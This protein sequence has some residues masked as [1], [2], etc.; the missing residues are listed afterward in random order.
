L[1]VRGRHLYDRC[2]EQVVL[3]GVNEMIVWS[4]GRDGNPEFS[5]IAKTGA[6][7]VRIV[8]TEEGTAAELDAVITNALGNHLVPMVEHHGATGDLSL[9]PVV[10]DYWTRRDV[11]A[12][13]KKA[14]GFLAA[15]HCQ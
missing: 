14:R 15:E 6:N 5:E 4:G 3:R 1:V 10:V 12:V 11:V 13:I 9:V 7:A 2:G 8:W